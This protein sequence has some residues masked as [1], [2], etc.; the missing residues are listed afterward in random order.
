VQVQVQVQVRR[1]ADAAGRACI[2][3]GRVARPGSTRR[4]LAWPAPSDDPGDRPWG[5]GLERPRPHFVLATY[6]LPPRIG[7]LDVVFQRLN[8]I[9]CW[10]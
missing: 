9:L 3:Q 2:R 8:A 7:A 5:P 1:L 4:D 6:V 10:L